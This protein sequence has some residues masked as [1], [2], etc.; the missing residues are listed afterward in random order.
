[1]IVVV[2]RETEAFIRD[3]GGLLFVWPSLSHGPR[4]TL[5]LLRASLDPPP[6]ALEFRRIVLPEFLLFLHPDMRSLPKELLLKLRGRSF[7]HVCAYWDGLA[8]VA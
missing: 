1:M 7:P 2:S 6:R 3:G 4:C 8:Y 5:T